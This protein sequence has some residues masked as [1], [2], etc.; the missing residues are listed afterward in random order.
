MYLKG[1]TLL[2]DLYPVEHS[3]R[4]GRH[5]SSSVLA[6]RKLVL[7]PIL[8]VG[9]SIVAPTVTATEPISVNYLGVRN[10]GMTAPA[11][12]QFFQPTQPMP[13]AGAGTG[14][15]IR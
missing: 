5:R 13:P 14:R 12:P 15:R 4:E 9:L 8:A 10:S 2:A 3:S 7:A 1:G 11:A 6:P